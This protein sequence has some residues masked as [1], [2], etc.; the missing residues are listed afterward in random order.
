VTVEA[1]RDGRV[2][3]ANN[4]LVNETARRA[5]A[6]KDAGAGLDIAVGVGD[7]VDRGAP[8]FTVHAETAG[9]LDAAVA[10]ARE[11]QPIRV[12]APDEALVER[13]SRPT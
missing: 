5:G 12:S 8:L 13:Y 4:R 2:S 6:P 3:H 10:F 9:K 7:P 11:N 1:R